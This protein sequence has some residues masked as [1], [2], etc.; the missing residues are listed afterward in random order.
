MDTVTSRDISH[1]DAAR[2]R[3]A[4]GDPG[5]AITV[6]SESVAMSDPLRRAVATIIEELAAGHGVA[7]SRVGPY[8][9]TGQAAQLLQVSR[10]TV[11]KLCEDGLLEFEQPGRHR[12]I[13]LESVQRFVDRAAKRRASGLAE[14]A[15]TD[16]GDDD[17]VVTTR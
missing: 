10:P 5:A 11:V 3:E 15:A 2:L 16:T 13:R 1:E 8:L 9:T 14:F 12:R 7:V 17:E 4:L 6:G